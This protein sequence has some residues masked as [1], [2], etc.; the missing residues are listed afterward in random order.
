MDCGPG[1]IQTGEQH[2]TSHSSGS[3]FHFLESDIHLNSDLNGQWD[4]AT[5][6]CPNGENYSTEGISTHEFGHAVGLDHPIQEGDPRKTMVPGYYPKC[7]ARDVES[8]DVN[9]MR[10]IYDDSPGD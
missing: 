2:D 6:S 10:A 1:C 4:N 5:D 8:S 3:P 9:G 7:W